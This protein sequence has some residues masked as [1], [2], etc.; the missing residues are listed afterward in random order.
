[1]LCVAKGCKVKNETIEA[2]IIASQFY[3]S[4]YMLKVRCGDILLK[5]AEF[6]GNIGHAKIGE[7]IHL[8]LRNDKVL[9]VL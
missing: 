1:M 8:A 5:V 6:R 2:K 7:T 3:G 4:H 9:H